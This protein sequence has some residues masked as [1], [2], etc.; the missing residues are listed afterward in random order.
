MEFDPT[1]TGKIY[2]ES[3]N[4]ICKFPTVNIAKLRA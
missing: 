2:I 4:I 3:I 1:F